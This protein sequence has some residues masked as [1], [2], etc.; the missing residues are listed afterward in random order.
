MNSKKFIAMHPW[1]QEK[2]SRFRRD[3]WYFFPEDEK[4]YEIKRSQLS[5]PLALK[6]LRD[7]V[8]GFMPQDCQGHDLFEHVQECEINQKWDLNHEKG[9]NTYIRGKNEEN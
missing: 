1:Y 9:T 6:A 5:N 3:E 2:P 8:D 4:E 7:C